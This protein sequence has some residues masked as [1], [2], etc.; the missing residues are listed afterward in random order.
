MASYSWLLYTGEVARNDVNVCTGN[1]S[2]FDGLSRLIQIV[3]F[4]SMEFTSC[5]LSLSF[6]LVHAD[7]DMITILRKISFELAC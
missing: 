2:N 5:M 1:I 4:S 3:G 7:Y 6:C